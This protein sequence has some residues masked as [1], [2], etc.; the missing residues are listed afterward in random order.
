MK[1]IVYL[2]A[3]SIVFPWSSGCV[4]NADQPAPHDASEQL[5][6]ATLFHQQAAEM[7]ALS[8]QA[9]N[10]ATLQMEQAVKNSQNPAELAI[11]L[12]LD[13]TVMDN[14]PF[15]AECILQNFNYPTGWAEW[16]NL[17]EATALP[18]AVDFLNVAV[19]RGIQVFYVSNR[20]EEFREATKKNFENAGIPLQSDA[21]LLLRTAES[22]KENRR[23]SISQQ[24]KIIMLV[25]DNLSDFHQIFD[26]QS[27]Q[28]RGS[29]T[30][31]LKAEFGNRFIVI[32]NA[33]YG[34][35][36]SAMQNHDFS[37]SDEEKTATY[38]K[39]LKGF[40]YAN[41]SE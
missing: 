6:I 1:R 13:E 14:S 37:L 30:D 3:L 19:A 27:T 4:S 10:L 24:F 26:G 34:D 25:G 38:F 12:D 21:H 33:M 11:V 20:K 31:S 36:V 23:Q 40:D 35:W 16:C 9:Y 15:Q 41:S 22:G 29:L 18:G 5:V 2:L 28:R 8:Y 17:A 32:P 39:L 7:R